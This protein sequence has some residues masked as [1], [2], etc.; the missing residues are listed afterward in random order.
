MNSNITPLPEEVTLTCD[1]PGCLRRAEFSHSILD[2][3]DE[4]GGTESL[5]KDHN[6]LTHQSSSSSKSDPVDNWL[7]SIKSKTEEPKT[8]VSGF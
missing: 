6:Y 4:D 3:E 5:C 1:Y 2:E 8:N 7:K